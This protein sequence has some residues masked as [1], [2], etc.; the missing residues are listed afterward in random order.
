MPCRR[1]YVYAHSRDGLRGR[2]L[3]RTGT[4]YFS[5][6]LH[7]FSSLAAIRSSNMAHALPKDPVAIFVG[8]TSGIGQAM[9]EAF[10]RYTKGNA[11]I[12]L[13]GR[14]R[15]AAESILASLPKP[16]AP[17]NKFTHEFIQCDVSLMKNVHTVTQQLTVRYPKINFLVTSTGFLS[18]K[19]RDETPEGIDTKLAA[20]YYARWKFTR[21]L[22]PSLSRA[23]DA[24]EEAKVVSVMGAG[25]GGA[26]DVNDLGLKKTFS[27]RVAGLAAPTYNDLM[28]EEFALRNPSISFIHAYP[29]FVRTPIMAKSDS[30]FMRIS[31]KIAIGLLYPFTVSPDQCAEY[32]WHNVFS[33][34]L[35][36]GSAGIKGA[37][38]RGSGGED[39]GTKYYFGDE[40]QRKKLWEHTWE[41][42]DVV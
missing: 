6:F 15:E 21:D 17:E 22:L 12:V 38:R 23:G 30:T 26:I 25:R 27:P 13:I 39:L 9:A 32:M 37:W 40:S 11:H 29:G 19:G 28:M 31:S 42:V 18:A 41:A 8:G 2:P 4:S 36:E 14:N 10:A 7:M 1:T 3:L 24:G 20:H 33:S 5:L 35:S 16:D 34:S